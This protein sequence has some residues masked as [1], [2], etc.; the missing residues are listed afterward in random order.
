M[1]CL[2][3]SG[4]TKQVLQQHRRRAGGD[5]YWCLLGISDG[6]I[7]RDVVRGECGVTV[8][9]DDAVGLADA[10]ER[11]CDD[12][13]ACARMGANARALFEAEFTQ[14]ITMGKWRAVLEEV[15]RK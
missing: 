2:G 12:A 14:A 1:Q 13:A 9:A 5:I 11:L 3:R 15:R 10:I 4:C 6:K 8:S 7:A